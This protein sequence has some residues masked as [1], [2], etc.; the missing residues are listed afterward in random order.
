MEKKQHSVPLLDIAFVPVLPE[1][2]LSLYL[3]LAFHLGIKELSGI[4]RP[5]APH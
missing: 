2:F 3:P 5:S 4:T 1:S